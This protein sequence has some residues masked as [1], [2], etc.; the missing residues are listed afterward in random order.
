MHFCISK[1]RQ[2]GFRELSPPVLLFHRLAP[3][4][5]LLSCLVLLRVKLVG[6]NLGRKKK[7]WEIEKFGKEEREGGGNRNGLWA[8]MNTF[9]FLFFSPK[10]RRR[11]RE[12]YRKNPAW[13]CLLINHREESGFFLL[14]LLIIPW[15]SSLFSFLLHLL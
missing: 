4:L 2:K 3:L 13:G 15:P 12:R 8:L 11:R 14:L 9:I 5:C 1:S 7:K 6:K 10:R